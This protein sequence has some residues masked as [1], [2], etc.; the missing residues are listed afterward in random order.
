MSNSLEWENFSIDGLG[1]LLLYDNGIDVVY[2]NWISDLNELG[3][4]KLTINP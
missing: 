4:Q 1:A 3:I 2:I